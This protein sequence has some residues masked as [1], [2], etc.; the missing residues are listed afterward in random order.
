[1]FQKLDLI[2]QFMDQICF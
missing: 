1:V 2:Y